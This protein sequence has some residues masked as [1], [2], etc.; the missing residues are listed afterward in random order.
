MKSNDEKDVVPYYCTLPMLNPD[1]KTKDS[2]VTIPM[3]AAVRETRRWSE[4][5]KL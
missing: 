3:D 5:L 4:E 2:K 1:H